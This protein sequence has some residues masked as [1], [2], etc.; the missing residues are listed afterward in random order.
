MTVVRDMGGVV[1]P[2]ALDSLG[3][4]TSRPFGLK[5]AGADAAI[6][7]LALEHQ[8]RGLG[9]L[10]V[11]QDAAERERKRLKRFR[12]QGGQVMVEVT[13]WHDALVALEPDIDGWW[14]KGHEAGG[15]V[16]EQCSFILLQKMVGHSDLPIHVR[17]GIN[18]QSAAG[19]SIGGGTSSTE[20]FPAKQ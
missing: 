1:L 9:F 6:A 3:R 14:A 5:V 7:T 17:G 19:C 18:V 20:S 11:D 2:E 15:W 8:E 12:T 13:A 16:G 10:I 4:F